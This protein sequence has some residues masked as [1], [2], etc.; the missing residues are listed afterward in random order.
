MTVIARL[1]S[2]GA[3]L[4][5]GAG[6]PLLPLRRTGWTAW[7]PHAAVALYAVIACGYAWHTLIEDFGVPN[8]AAGTL[9]VAHALALPAALYWPLAAWWA[10]LALAVATALAAVPEQGGGPLWPGPAMAIHL[11]VLALAGARARPRVPVAM[12]ALTLLAGCGLALVLPASREPLF[13]IAAMAVFSAGVLIASGALRSRAEALRRLAEQEHISGRERARRELL[14]ER[15]RIARELHDV[16]AHHMSV[17]AI[18]AEAAPLRVP[19]PP[20]EL[21]GAFATIRGNAVEALSELHRVLDVLRADPAR[22]ES[23]GP[24][25]P[26]EP[27][28]PTLD[29]LGDLLAGVRGAGLAVT[30]ET[31]GTPRPL[32]QG[33]QLTA[34]RIV[35]EALSNV[36]RHAPGSEVTVTLEHRPGRLGVEVAN[37]APARPAPPSRGGHG[38]TGMRERAA[39]LGGTLTAG[40]LPGGGHAVRAEL[41]TGDARGTGDAGEQ[42]GAA[43]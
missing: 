38:L 27:P 30:V 41:P 23:A 29:R 37:T 2:M 32:A 26:A 39:M 22:D 33:V 3:G 6:A 40:P 42:G 11:S 14:E 8:L 35:Q 16:V 28:Q 20:A 7:A 19:D 21:A 5:P 18:Q 43:P 34:Y 17:I 4:A 25:D 10:S 15:A 36:L 31:R 12:W 1:R 24:A 9:T 13:G